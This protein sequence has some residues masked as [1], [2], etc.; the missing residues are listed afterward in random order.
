[1]NTNEPPFPCGAAV[2]MEVVSY[3]FEQLMN[4][5]RL[6]SIYPLFFLSTNSGGFISPLSVL[7]EY[8][9]EFTFLYP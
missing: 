5:K 4:Q 6:A 1:M 7:P 9:Y 3:V 2:P 8:F